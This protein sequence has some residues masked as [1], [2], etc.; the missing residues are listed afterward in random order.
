M[1][2]L[3]DPD[4]DQTL[5]QT[6]A[7]LLRIGQ[8]DGSDQGAAL[9]DLYRRVTEPQ[10]QGDVT[11]RWDADNPV[12][13]ETTQPVQS[14][15]MPRG[16]FDPIA[17]G[18]PVAPGATRPMTVGESQG[19]RDAG[20]DT[21]DQLALLAGGLGLPG[22]ASGEARML[23]STRRG[24]T[25]GPPRPTVSDI[26]GG[27]R[28]MMA[29]PSL[30]S[31]TPA[32]ASVAA[33][34]EPHLIP[35]PDGGYVGAPS[36]V[37]TPDDIQ[38]M[39]DNLDSA[40]DAGAHGRDWYGRVRDWI[41]GVTGGQ[42]VRP[43]AEGLGLFSQQADPDTNLQ[44][45]LQARNAW[46]RGQ[47]VDLART[48]QQARTYNTGMA[49]KEAADTPGLTDPP[50]SLGP[51][52]EP[53]AWHMSPDLEAL[54][55]V[56][57]KHGYYVSDTGDGVSMINA[58]NAQSPANGVEQKARL[59]GGMQ[60]EIQQALP[61]ATITPGRHIGDYA[62]LADQLAESV[63]GE[64]QATTKVLSQLED[65][66]AKAPRMYDTLMDNPDVAS[67]AQGNLDR[68]TPEMRAAR[69]DYVKMLQIVS[70]GNLRG[71]LSHVAKVGA[72]GL[73]AALATLSATR[74]QSN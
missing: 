70:G 20:I 44:F 54:Q 65:M 28:G 22:A 5:G 63:K 43:T 25:P 35:K 45:Y 38:T 1:P 48:G 18:T 57:D 8:D 37:K 39:R 21:F 46:E 9:A 14:L 66:Q 4:D 56:A 60:D 53:Y 67:K 13:T 15:S 72:G 40:I 71:L 47:P 42:D 12:G 59:A 41:T 7:G 52:T 19:V 31:M 58:G 27:E 36:W 74:D 11:P 55:G 61:G 33:S 69:P 23:A 17:I 30:R 64:G 6:G 68:L 10:P 16:P 3:L 51:K 73:P 50:M 26:G 29:L 2:S 32:E 49:A 62:D 34:S 24:L